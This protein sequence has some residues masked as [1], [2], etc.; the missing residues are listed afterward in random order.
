M[1]KSSYESE[2]EPAIVPEMVKH[3]LIEEKSRRSLLLK[4]ADSILEP[5]ITEIIR[6]ELTFRI[7]S[8]RNR[9]QTRIRV[10]FVDQLRSSLI[11]DF[12]SAEVRN[13]LDVE[14]RE[15]KKTEAIQ[16]EKEILINETLFEVL[17]EVMIQQRE[18][19]LLERNEKRISDVLQ[20]SWVSKQMDF[21]LISPAGR[22]ILA[23]HKLT[24]QI[25]FKKVTKNSLGHLNFSQ[26][27][28]VL[29]TKWW[30]SAQVKK[31][32]PFS[33][34]SILGKPDTPPTKENPSCPASTPAEPCMSHIPGPSKPAAEPMITSSSIPP[35][36]IPSSSSIAIGS[37]TVTAAELEI[38][39][40]GKNNSRRSSILDEII[41]LQKTLQK[42]VL[43][44]TPGV[45][46]PNPLTPGKAF[47][48]T[49]LTPGGTMGHKD[50]RSDFEKILKVRTPA[51]NGT[52]L[53][54]T[55]TKGPFPTNNLS[56]L[57][58]QPG[59]IIVSAP[60]VS[61][62]ETAGQPSSANQQP[63]SLLDLPMPDLIPSS[64]PPN[65]STKSTPTVKLKRKKD[66]LTSAYQDTDSAGKFFRVHIN[67]DNQFYASMTWKVFCEFILNT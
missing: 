21:D 16:E 36:N 25:T 32:N 53:G 41:F 26:S 40:H 23:S 48:K 27:D 52:P 50:Y 49:P 60:S 13:F 10:L 42:S 6:E 28:L 33:I 15:K 1:A 5:V 57:S 59:P 12:V 4:A 61:K 34:A 2:I 67:F 3:L 19:F 51:A 66:Y 39:L 30:N 65:S 18:I 35:S 62:T 45:I 17:R 58:G 47:P 44:K 31:N 63:P 9:K 14:I 64:N 20:N 56:G 46:T 54:C 29:V 38:M 43:G 11:E 55:P 8:E 24:E 37:G 7:I 22:A